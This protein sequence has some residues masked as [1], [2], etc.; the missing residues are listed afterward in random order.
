MDFND[1][2]SDVVVLDTNSRLDSSEMAYHKV[3]EATQRLKS[4]GCQQFY[5]KTCSVFRGNIGMEFDAMLDALEKDFAVVVLGFPKNGRVTQ[6]GIHYVHGKLLAES[7]F[8]N[9][10]IHPMRESDL[11]KILQSQ[12]R[13]KV[14]LIS[15]EIIS[16]GIEVLKEAIQKKRKEV[17]YLI[18]DVINQ[19]AL[20]LIAHAVKTEPILCGSSALGEELPGAWE[21]PARRRGLIKTKGF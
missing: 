9:D 4:A 14:G 3:F 21:F 7:E 8:R 11:V 1:H 15:H 5:N 2:P 20:T 13:R 6:Q 12:T 16:Q 17:N 10:P 18:L 19:E